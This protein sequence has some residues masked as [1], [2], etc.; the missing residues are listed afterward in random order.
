M[1]GVLQASLDYH[2]G[3][4]ESSEGVRELSPSI[5]V[6]V[7]GGGGRKRWNI[8]QC[9]PILLLSGKHIPLT[10]AEQVLVPVSPEERS[11]LGKE[12]A[13]GKLK[14]VKRHRAMET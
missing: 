13:N 9:P 14:T 3:C 8:C 10:A 12:V 5:P 7:S 1:E 11:S 6:A 2:L 4:R